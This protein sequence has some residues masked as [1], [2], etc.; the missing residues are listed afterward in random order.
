MSEHLPGSDTMATQRPLS[1]FESA[2]FLAAAPHLGSVPVLGL[3]LYIGTTVRGA[4]DPDI[5]RQVLADLAAGHPLL[6]SRVVEV[7]GA[8]HFRI[9]DDYRVPFAVRDGG[10]E[11]YRRLTN[12]RP[13]WDAGLFQAQVLRRDGVDQVVLSIHHGIA[14]GRSAFALLEQMWRRY[15]AYVAGIP[16]PRTFSD[17]LP[18]A[19]DIRLAEVTTRA[20]IELFLAGVRAGAAAMAPSDAPRRLPTGGVSNDPCGRLGLRRIELSPERTTELMNTARQHGISVNSLLTGVA[21]AAVRDRLTPGAGKLPLMCGHAVDLRY[22]LWPRVAAETVVNCASGTGTLVAVDRDDDP[23]A[24]GREVAEGMRVAKD[25]R[26]PALF[27]RASQEP[28]DAFTAAILGA[29]PT[30]ALSNMG[31]VQAHS[32]PDELRFV[33]DDIYAVAPGMPPKLSVFTVGE[34]LTI[35]MEYDSAEYGHPWMADLGAA[36]VARLDRVCATVLAD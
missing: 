28:L 15:T 36:L 23:I 29:P 14:D 27:L 9:D 21:L 24:L 31:L 18:G 11:E 3:P 26:F 7:N 17:Q 1:P 6:R 20:E 30:F 5:L 35:Q 12:S 25:T 16:L 33:R 34:R 10:P 2:Y 19:V 8:P 4:L 22:E 32:L 13:D